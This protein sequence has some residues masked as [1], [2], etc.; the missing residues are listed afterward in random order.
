MRKRLRREKTRGTRKGYTRRK[1]TKMMHTIEG[2]KQTGIRIA[3]WNLGSSRLKK[4]ME[5][6]EL[7]IKEVQPDIIGISEGNLYAE[8]NT[9]ETEIDGYDLILSDAI[10]NP[11][12]KYS[13]VMAYV[14]SSLEYKKRE[15]LMS[16]TIF[17]HMD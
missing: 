13:R 11:N 6:I 3:H 15:D 7:A 9:R 17:F 12:I 14:K 16:D 2:N 5:D 8:V 1:K 10:L 4:K